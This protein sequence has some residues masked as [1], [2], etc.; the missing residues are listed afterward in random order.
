MNLTTLLL[1]VGFPFLMPLIVTAVLW[2]KLE[3]KWLYLVVSILCIAGIA[4]LSLASLRDWLVP[5][6]P[7][8]LPSDLLGFNI[9]TAH[10]DHV[11]MLLADAIVLAIGL[12]I[13][14]WLFAALRRPS[15][16]SAVH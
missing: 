11:A 8:P 15:S 6:M 2:K 16:A 13:L 1:V 10:Q 7:D 3:R 9:E 5:A 4:D 14:A 12:P